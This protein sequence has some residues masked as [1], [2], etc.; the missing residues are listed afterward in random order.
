MLI[1]PYLPPR[2]MVQSI[3]LFVFSLYLFLLVLTPYRSGL[4]IGLSNLGLSKPLVLYKD[5]DL[6]QNSSKPL[7]LQSSP[8]VLDKSTSF[9]ISEIKRVSSG[10]VK[11][12][13]TI[14]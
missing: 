11:R 4:H 7:R 1:Y 13:S 9:S 3:C 5:H 6:T 10:P 8:E 2:D 14:T 12:A